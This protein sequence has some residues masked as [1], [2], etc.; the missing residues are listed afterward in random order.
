MNRRWELDAMRGLML[1]LMTITHLPTRF[2][3]PFGQPFGFVS[4]AEG[5]VMLSAY[6]AGLVYSQKQLRDGD[7]QMRSAF[8][9][10]ALK[11]WLCQ[12]GLMLFA[13]TVIALI[14]ALHHADAVN[15]LLSF[16]WER[17]KLAFVTGMLLIYNPALLD[18]LPMYVLFM[19]LSPLLLLH[20]RRQG[21]LP[22]IALSLALWLAAQFELGRFV[23]DEVVVPAKVRVPMSQTGAF[24]V[25]AWQFLWVFGLWLGASHAAAPDAPPQRFP[26]WMVALALAIA[27]TGLVWR[28]AVGQAPFPGN[29]QLNLLFDKWQLAPLRLIDFMALVLL[30]MHFGPWLKAHLPRPKVL[31]TLGGAALPVFCAHLVLVLLALAWFGEPKPERALWIDLA[32]V[33]G[34]FGVLYAVACVSAEL[35]RQAAAA[36]KRLSERR[37]RR[38]GPAGVAA[39]VAGAVRSPTSTAHSPS[40]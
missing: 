38:A 27:L 11:I 26:R 25:F 13:L 20:G 19:L 23:F 39:V 14:G 32:L 24:D 40:H 28:H 22:I 29:G 4:A 6:M 15:N 7:D 37:S 21:W 10:R 1:V 2:S 30:L 18:I 16:Y 9:K 17:P 34:T 3:D 36:K 8:L 33:A 35:D 5:F 31:E 12:A